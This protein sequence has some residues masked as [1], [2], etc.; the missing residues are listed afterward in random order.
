MIDLGEAFE[1]QDRVELKLPPDVG[2]IKPPEPTDLNA[3]DAGFYR[4][5]VS[6]SGDTLIANRHLK[7]NVYRFVPEQWP[8]LKA[9]FGDMAAQ[10]DQ[11]IVL[12]M[13]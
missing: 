10:D 12:R 4:S 6:Q 13:E 7:I 9:W 1:T 11:P 3:G 5:S 8:G 2:E